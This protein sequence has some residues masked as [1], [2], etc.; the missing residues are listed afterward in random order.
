MSFNY[1]SLQKEILGIFVERSHLAQAMSID[2]DALI[3]A[4]QLVKR[5][6]Y[7]QEYTEKQRARRALVRA[8]REAS[9]SQEQFRI[10]SILREN[11]AWDIVEDIAK[12]HVVS[13]NAILSRNRFPLWAHAR[14]HAWKVTRDTFAISYQEMAKLFGVPPTSIASGIK[15]HESKYMQKR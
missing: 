15:I 5:A 12:K 14:H 2:G 4:K 1:S 7:R 6:R 9:C 10:E 11:G 3:F 8:K 13:T